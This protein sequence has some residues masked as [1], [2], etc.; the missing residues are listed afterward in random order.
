MKRWEELSGEEVGKVMKWYGN[1]CKFSENYFPGEEFTL[2]DRV[3][4]LSI[5]KERIH[6][7]DLDDRYLGSNIRM[8]VG[9]GMREF[10]YNVKEV[11]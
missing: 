3:L 2:V 10:G 6:H 7:L 9:R 4:I 1:L 11:R 5:L 8:V